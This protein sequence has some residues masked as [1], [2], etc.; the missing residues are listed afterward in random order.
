MIFWYLLLAHL[1]ADYPLQPTWMVLQKARWSV[2]SLHVAIHFLITA[3][4]VWPVIGEVWIYMLV[5]AGMHLALD[6][7]K[8]MVNRMRPKWVI[9]PY[10]VDQF[11]HVGTILGISLLVQRQA[12]ELPL[13]AEPAW[14]ILAIVFLLVTYV[15]HISERIFS[16]R[17][18][19]Y[20]QEV[21]ERLWTRMAARGILL[22]VLL[23]AWFFV[24]QPGVSLAAA[25]RFPYAS[26][27]YPG[28]AF[29]TDMLVSMAGFLFIYLVL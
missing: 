11:I 6:V 16:Y 10:L 25:V 2:L 9:G 1:I 12:G 13:E 28:R 7:A 26:S 19:E 21:I 14:L 20:R 29:F 4:L 17:Q 3:I 18:P 23:L 8:N 15:W 22:F 5:L 27:K 24:P